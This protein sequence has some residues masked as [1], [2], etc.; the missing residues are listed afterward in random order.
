VGTPAWANG[1]RGPAWTPTSAAAFASFARA[2]AARYP[3]VERWLVWNEPN[4]RR[5]LRPTS[6]KVYVTRLL[7]PGRDAIRAV[8]PGALVAGGATAPRG[9]AGG[10]S[11][12][13][14]IRGMAA[15]GA[16]LDAYAHHPYPLTPG[17]SPVS[18]GCRR[19]ST[20]T[21]ATLDR[22]LQNVRR[23]FGAV[24]IW[25]TEYGYQTT[26][27]DRFG[28]S[29][30]RQAA[31]LRQAVGRAERAPR[32]DV[33]IQFLYRDEPAV[34]GWQSGLERADGTPKPA[35]DAFRAPL[36]GRTG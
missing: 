32:V 18:G 28:V 1:G 9:G 34:G 24:R 19:C 22:L 17:E 11:P 5:W 7:N 36:A 27:P 30:T 31:Y 4:Q 35:L 25:L 13:A 20:I 12:V 33:L 29:Y 10:V 3:W 21:M 23:S 15:A 8:I 16:R 6:P 26:P 14:W 2:A